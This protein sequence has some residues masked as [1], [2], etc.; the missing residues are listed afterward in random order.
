MLKKHQQ[1]CLIGQKEV[2]CDHTEYNYNAEYSI[3][4]LHG[5]QCGYVDI[6]GI[7]NPGWKMSMVYT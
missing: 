1:E 7:H 6:L 2:C 5:D 4:C 3:S